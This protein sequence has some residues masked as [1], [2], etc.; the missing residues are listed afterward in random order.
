M[1]RKI[2]DVLHRMQTILQEE[3]SPFNTATGCV[4]YADSD[5]LQ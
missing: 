1:E 4:D 2:M 3:Q 5:L